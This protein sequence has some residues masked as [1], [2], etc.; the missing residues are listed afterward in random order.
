MV[1]WFY[2]Y[3][4]KKFEQFRKKELVTWQKDGRLKLERK[5]LSVDK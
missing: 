1:P 5:N 2:S 3:K 4:C